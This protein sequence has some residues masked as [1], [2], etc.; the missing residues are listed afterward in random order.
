MKGVLYTVVLI[1]LF[2]SMIV[3]NIFLQGI[4]YYI[5]MVLSAW[6]AS[7]LIWNKYF[8]NKY[9]LL[10]VLNVFIL[11]LMLVVSVFIYNQFIEYRLY[12][13]DINGDSI[14]SKEEQTY[15][16]MRYMEM[17]TNSLGR[18]LIYFTGIIYSLVSTFILFTLVRLYN[19]FTKKQ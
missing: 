2:I 5:T 13:F 14:F 19:L 4:E 1:F 8:K 10:Y 6:F 18:S 16:Q 11:Y 9:I 15:E 12:Q 17:W 7:I 3:M